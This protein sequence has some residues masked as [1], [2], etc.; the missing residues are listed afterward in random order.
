MKP[1]IYLIAIGL[2]GAC[3]NVGNQ[4]EVFRLPAITAPTTKDKPIYFPF[5]YLTSSDPVFL[6][7]FKATTDT[8]NMV[9]MIER[10]PPERLYLNDY[11][12]QENWEQQVKDSIK[13][14][15]FS[16]YVDY[17]YSVPYSR[18]GN[19]HFYYYPVYIVNQTASTQLFNGRLDHA[20][21]TQEALDSNG[22]WRPIEFKTAFSDANSFGLKVHPGEFVM[23]LFTKYKG[24]YVTR[25]RVRL[26]IG[27]HLYISKSFPGEINYSQFHFEDYNPNSKMDEWYK[28]YYYYGTSPLDI[29]NKK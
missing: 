4:H 11:L 15:G 9:D 12:W 8:V 1:L 13:S 23:C 22:K 19:G 18:W 5:K 28:S 27:G 10:M 21:G 2:F 26:L 16:L 7:K 25:M 29:D 24:N 20:F 3:N 14:D 17:A 6:A